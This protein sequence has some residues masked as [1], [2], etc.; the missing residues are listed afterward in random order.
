MNERVQKA[1]GNNLNS[2]VTGRT[3]C[4]LTTSE[5]EQRTAVSC[6]KYRHRSM[7]I[8][9]HHMA[10]TMSS[11]SVYYLYSVYLLGRL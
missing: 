8:G 4:K 3:A 11:V 7:L 2:Y 6:W 1:T 10:F 9:F 5:T